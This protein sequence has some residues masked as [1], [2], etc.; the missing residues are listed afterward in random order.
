[1]IIK[2]SKLDFLYLTA[3][4]ET[5]LSSGRTRFALPLL[6]LPPLA[7]DPCD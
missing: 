1:M 7:D 4:P 5:F 2:S 6:T 3:S